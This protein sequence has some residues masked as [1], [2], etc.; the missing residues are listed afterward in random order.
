[1]TGSTMELRCEEASLMLNEPTGS[2][3]DVCSQR[4]SAVVERGWKPFARPCT[5]NFVHQESQAVVS[6]FMEFSHMPKTVNTTTYAFALPEWVLKRAA[7]LSDADTRTAD[8]V[9]S[10]GTEQF[11]VSQAHEHEIKPILDEADFWSVLDFG[12]AARQAVA[13]QPAGWSLRKCLW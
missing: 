3:E 10:C 6:K 12:E 2:V 9:A 7:S 13:G 4:D 5:W 8:A 1:M 11:P